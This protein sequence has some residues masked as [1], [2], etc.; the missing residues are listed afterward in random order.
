MRS[1]IKIGLDSQTTHRKPLL[2][3]LLLGLFLLRNEARRL[4]R[5]LYQAPPRSARLVLG[6]TPFLYYIRD[7]FSLR[8]P[9]LCHIQKIFQLGALPPDPRSDSQMIR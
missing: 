5:L 6:S 9:G 4:F 1:H 3:F 2:L 7:Q 8:K